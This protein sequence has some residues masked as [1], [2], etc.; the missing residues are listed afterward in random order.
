MAVPLVADVKL[1][2]IEVAQRAL[3]RFNGA[4]GQHAEA[5]K[6]VRE[7][8]DLT[9]S[10]MLKLWA[11]FQLLTSTST[12]ASAVFAGFGAALGF[13]IDTILLPFL[14]LLI[15]IEMALFRFGNWFSEQGP[16]VR[17]A[18][19]LLGAALLFAFG[20]P[21]AIA[22]GV[23]LA[24]LGLMYA[25]SNSKAAAI[26]GAI[27]LLAAALIGLAVAFG[28]LTAAAAPWLAIALAVLG[29]ILLIRSAWLALTGQAQTNPF[30]STGD[31]GNAVGVNVGGL[32]GGGVPV[33]PN[34]AGAGAGSTTNIT[35]N[36]APITLQGFGAS[37]Q[38][39]RDAGIALQ[40]HKAMTLRFG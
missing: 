15:N 24:L 6:K 3:D 13:I 29:V 25:W 35:N 33:I 7:R 34:P 39:G 19:L 14:P 20:T 36:Q 17:A 12:I 38:G 37:S 23:I 40:S 27:L 31:L 4:L 30:P 22:I 1:R 16:A 26:T 21:T 28:I 8:Q 18:L 9:A 11:A 32:G 10:S 2:G 5:Q